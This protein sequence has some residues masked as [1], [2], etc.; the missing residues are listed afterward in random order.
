MPTINI[1]N[2]SGAQVAISGLNGLIIK[3][4]SAYNGFF[5]NF[6]IEGAIVEL[7]SWQL[8]GYISYTIVADPST[9]YVEDSLVY[10][11]TAERVLNAG[12]NTLVYDT[13]LQSQYVWD[14]TVNVWQVVCNSI[15][16]DR[17]YYVDGDNGDDTNDG[18]TSGTSFKTFDFLWSGGVR[19][20]PREINATVTV[21][22]SG[23][24]LSVSTV[25]HLTLDHFYGTGSISIEGEWTDL[26]ASE[27]VAAGGYDNVSSSP[28]YKTYLVAVPSVPWVVDAYKGKFIKIDAEYYPI[29]SNTADTL[30]SIALPSLADGKAFTIVEATKMKAALVSDPTTI[31]QYS[32][33]K[34]WGGAVS[35]E[36]CI[37]QR[38][39]LITLDMMELKRTG[40]GYDS[41]IT[42]SSSSKTTVNSSYINIEYI[43]A[44][45][46][47][48]ESYTPKLYLD[49]SVL[50]ISYQT[51]I[52][53]GTFTL[54][55]SIITG[56]G[57]TLGLV[58]GSPACILNIHNSRIHNHKIGISNSSSLIIG[59]SVMININCLF[60]DCDTAMGTTFANI[61]IGVYTLSYPTRFLNCT[62]AIELGSN[63]FAVGKNQTFV[64]SGI[65]TDIQVDSISTD[66]F[67]NIKAN[68]V[69]RNDS[70][71][72]IV[73]QDL[74]TTL[75][76]IPPK[77]DMKVMST[78]AVTDPPTAAE[79][80]AE[81]GSPATVGTGFSVTIDNNGA[82]THV[83]TCTSDGTNWWTF[84]GTVAP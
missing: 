36:G 69:I 75:P 2:K 26:I 79:L 39:D 7:N 34:T 38:I 9:D 58:L 21:H 67:A 43:S 25:S 77:V 35:V 60:E 44:V 68:S 82:G 24:I 12:T 6:V 3:K 84:T 45:V 31:V 72:S 49:R 8:K 52:N 59:G 11:T 17:T 55:Q 48:L 62:T 5:S 14:N 19:P 37:L 54:S 20:L 80:T 73:Y 74:A 56:D 46:R 63:L 4:N 23:T 53:L 42:I 71:G 61:S 65:T 81:F 1:Y 40:G 76:Y 83:Y 70:G 27:V 33:P 28:T 16:Q 22:C 66:T 78:L 47:Y 30:E 57:T 18:L 10:L 41:G 51:L 13:D 32:N 15:E 29:M 64:S 50:F